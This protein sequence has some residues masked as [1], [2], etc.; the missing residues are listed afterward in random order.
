MGTDDV[1]SSSSSFYEQV[2]DNEVVHVQDNTLLEKNNMLIS[3]YI[4]DGRAN[5]KI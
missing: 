5:D 4:N 3:A 1:D 2:N